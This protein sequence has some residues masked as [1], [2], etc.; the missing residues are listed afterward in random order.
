MT[1]ALGVRLTAQNEDKLYVEL[2]INAQSDTEMQPTTNSALMHS[3]GTET[4]KV[5]SRL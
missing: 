3:N 5:E 4:Q 2:R 1:S